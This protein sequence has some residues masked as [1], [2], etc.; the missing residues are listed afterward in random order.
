MLFYKYIQTFSFFR[1]CFIPLFFIVGITYNE[2]TLQPLIRGGL[3]KPFFVVAFF[4]SLYTF[5][6]VF[7]A[8]QTTFAGVQ[9]HIKTVQSFPSPLLPLMLAAVY[10]LLFSLCLLLPFVL[11]CVA[12][13]Q[14]YLQTC[15]HFPKNL[16]IFN[17]LQQISMVL[18]KF[19]H[20]LSTKT[21][22]CAIY[23]AN[24]FAFDCNTR[25]HYII[26]NNNAIFAVCLRVCLQC[27]VVWY[28]VGYI[29]AKLPPLQSEYITPDFHHLC[30]FGIYLF[31]VCPL[32]CAVVGVLRWINT[33][34]LCAVFVFVPGSVLVVC[35][36]VEVWH[37]LFALIVF[38]QSFMFR[39]A[40]LDLVYY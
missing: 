24:F 19:I 36:R 11:N 15:K 26:T 25:V 21:G 9:L 20:I 5:V 40:I 10:Y 33:Y 29:P 23:K 6:I 32:P 8:I 27:V 18:P 34:Y 4:C 3:L 38:I 1:F 37:I 13:V 22:K 2:A 30:K 39:Y 14:T 12:K 31:C 28:S 7:R 17:L 16:C 35:C